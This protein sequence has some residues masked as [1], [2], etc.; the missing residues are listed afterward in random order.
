M[1]GR[2]ALLMVLAVVLYALVWIG[3]GINT[4]RIRRLEGQVAVLET[5]VMG[6]CEGRNPPCT[7]T[8]E[9]PW[10]REVV[11]AYTPEE[12]DFT[13]ATR[14]ALWATLAAE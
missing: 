11:P 13:E 6:F 12:P 7:L 3:G 8:P 9:V 1:R 14:A 4:T 5:V 10:A 2:I